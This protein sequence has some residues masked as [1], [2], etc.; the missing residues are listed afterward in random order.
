MKFFI[1]DFSSK[2]WHR[3]WHMIKINQNFNSWKELHYEVPQRSAL[4]SLLFNICLN[5]LTEY[6]EVCN[7]AD[8]TILSVYDKDQNSLIKILEH[9]SSLRIEFFQNN[10]IKSNQEKF[11]L[12]VSQ[13]KHENVWAQ[14]QDEVVWESNKSKLLDLEIDRNLN[15]NEYVSPLCKKDG[16]KIEKL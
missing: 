12:L 3:R 11:Q 10:D 2:R 13:N 6:T 4:G 5:N 9:D 14:I 16:Q 1:K 15:F 8:D 7:F